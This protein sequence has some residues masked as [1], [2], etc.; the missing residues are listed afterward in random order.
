[1]KLLM[2][3]YEKMLEMQLHGNIL[4]TSQAYIIWNLKKF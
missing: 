2:N 3:K 1:M 4:N